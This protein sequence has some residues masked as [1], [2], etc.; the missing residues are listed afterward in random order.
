MSDEAGWE[1]Y[2]LSEKEKAVKIKEKIDFI[3]KEID[4]MVYE[5]YELSEEEIKVIKGNQL[6]FSYKL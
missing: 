4:K 6:F 5:L 1:D 3:D 2:F